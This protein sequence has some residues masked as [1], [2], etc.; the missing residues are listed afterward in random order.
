MV[1]NFGRDILMDVITHE[2]HAPA[3]VDR[4]VHTSWQPIFC[5]LYSSVEELALVL[6]FLSPLIRFTIQFTTHLLFIY[7]FTQCEILSR[8]QFASTK[9]LKVLL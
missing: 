2:S 8:W 5:G 7:F 6:I 9:K 4:R 1:M 3:I